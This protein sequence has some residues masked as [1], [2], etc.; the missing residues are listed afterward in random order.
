VAHLFCELAFRLR[1]AGLARQDS[2]PLPLTQEEMADALGLS[3]VHV[4]RILQRLRSERLITLR[5]RRLTI[6]DWPA[7]QRVG[8]FDP[9]YLSVHAPPQPSGEDTQPEGEDSR[10]RA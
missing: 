4:N 6:H 8:G 3:V 10:P 1:A 5:A 2:Y 9:R 7:F